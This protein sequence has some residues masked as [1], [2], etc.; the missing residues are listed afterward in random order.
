MFLSNSSILNNP[1]LLTF[2]ITGN[3]SSENILFDIFKLT[4]LYLHI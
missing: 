3:I 1:K 2:D 4:D